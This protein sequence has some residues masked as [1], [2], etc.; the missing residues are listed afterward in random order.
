MDTPITY[1]QLIN[2]ETSDTESN[3]ETPNLYISPMNTKSFTLNNDYESTNSLYEALETY[4]KTYLSY[5]QPLTTEQITLHPQHNSIFENPLISETQLGFDSDDPLQQA[6]MG[7]QKERFS[8]LFHDPL[9]TA[10]PSNQ[11]EPENSFVN[12]SDVNSYVAK[13]DS[14]KYSTAFP[15]SGTASLYQP[16]FLSETSFLDSE[17]GDDDDGNMFSDSS[18]EDEWPFYDLATADMSNQSLE[19]K[20]LMKMNK[21]V[22]FT[23]FDNSFFH[24]L[25]T[26][27][28]LPSTLPLSTYRKYRKSVPNIQ[29]GL[30][31]KNKK[32]GPRRGSAPSSYIKKSSSTLS[33]MAS[34]SS[35]SSL[36]NNLKRTMRV[37]SSLNSL[38]TQEDDIFEH[39]EHMCE[40]SEEE[41]D[42]DCHTSKKKSKGVVGLLKK[43]KN[44]DKAC[45]HCKRSHLR[46]D[47]M[48]PCRRCITTGK[49]GC[50]DVQH[51]PRGRPKLSRN[52]E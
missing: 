47:E 45:N 8:W 13:I 4:N 35:L 2:F 17:D 20:L 6:L 9:D 27:S 51:K 30:G 37:S 40:E 33:T 52:L 26:L 46:C 32:K 41:D 7:Q 50:K 48:R 19:K 5:L 11:L 43:G 23:T 14:M 10:I 25:T 49:M 38:L 24:D 42:D 18:E 39:N 44:V 28:D 36:S 15:Y 29:T 12:L 21:P 22:S 1:S 16:N 34:S 3:D 31:K